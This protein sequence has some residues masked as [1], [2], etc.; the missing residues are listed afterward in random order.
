MCL[1]LVCLCLVLA[2][3][4]ARGDDAPRPEE[5][6]FF[7]PSQPDAGLQLAHRFL[8]LGSV[9]LQ[10]E[11]RPWREGTQFRVQARSGVIVPLEP[12]HDGARPALVVVRYRYLPTGLPVRRELWPLSPPPRVGDDG[13]WQPQEGPDPQDTSWRAG[14]LDVQGSKTVQVNSGSRREMTVDQNLRLTIMGQLTEDIGVRAFLSDD[15]LPVIP[16]G[17]TEE[18]RDIDKV[19]VELKA[20]HWDATLGDF[21]ARRRGTAFGNYRRK[22]QGF[23]LAARPGDTRFQLLAGSPRGLYRTLQIRGQEANQGPYYLGTTGG[24]ENLFLVAG[25]ERVTLDGEVLTRGADRDYTIDYVAGTVTFTYRRLITAEST[26]VVEYEQGEGPYGRTVVGAGGGADFQVPGL[27]VPGFFQAR[28]IRERDD[29]HRLRRGELSTADEAV[30]AAAGDDIYLAVASGVQEVDEGTGLYDAVS[31]G[32]EIIYVHNPAGGR[33]N[34]SLYYVGMGNGDYVLDFLSETGQ[35]VFEHRGQ[36]LGNYRIGRPLE[37]PQQQS[38]ATLSAAVGDT[39]TT[40]LR[41]EMNF[42]SLDQNLLSEVDDADNHATAGRLS[43]RLAPRRLAGGTF[44]FEG[45][46]EHRQEGFAP[47]QVA[48]TVFAYDRWGLAERARRAG[49]LDEKDSESAL[50]ARWETGQGG[51]RLVFQGDWGRLRHGAALEADRLAGQVDWQALGLTGQHSEHVADARDQRD[52]LNIRHTNRRHQLGWR[53][54]PVQPE[55]RYRQRSWQDA[56]S[57]GGRASGYRLEEVGAGL[58]SAPGAAWVWR[59]DFQRSLADSLETGTWRHQ[60]DG[61][62]WSAALTTPRFGGMRLV[63]EGTQRRTLSPGRPEQRTRL[64]RLNLA[65]QWERLGSDWSLGYRLDNSRTQ[66]LDRQLV[67]VGERQGDYNENGDYLG[68]DLGS[69]DLIQA[70]TDSLLATTGVVADLNWRQGFGFLGQDRW[71]ASWTALTLASVEARSTSRDVG[72]LLRLAPSAVFDDGRTVL[73]NFQFTEEWRFL[74][75]IPS[76]DLRGKFEYRQ[77]M[78]RQYADHPEDRLM[79]GWRVNSTVNVSRRNSLRGRYSRRQESRQ[80]TESV[81]SS[82]RPYRSLVNEYEVAWG[83]RPHAGLRL[84]LAAIYT[85]RGETVSGVAQQEYALRPGARSR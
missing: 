6:E 20:P 44:S 51:R 35:R 48:K 9:R 53:R 47:F 71:Y 85:D 79:R 5:T 46:H 36:G 45:H 10:V 32:G 72:G 59:V 65:G 31:A 15:N 54:G 16:E 83:F 78:D 50:S 8:E 77:T 12:W 84:N 24:A 67:Y 33:Y 25:S 4:L 76:V 17:N 30:L 7:L 61:R 70:A 21:V 73:G 19:L 34:L 1:C 11:G 40:H 18:L 23:S 80:S 69:Y 57:R 39:A 60:R 63:G 29:P 42:S 38:M 58:R 75:H 13:R 68:E 49:F 41:A 22:L 14:Q 3:A 64:G 82:R 37:R 26:I 2:P 52:P 43:A 81:A 66:V 62:T 27:A 56:V 28:V 55:I 74:Q